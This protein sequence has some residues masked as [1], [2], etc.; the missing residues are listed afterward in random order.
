MTNSHKNGSRCLQVFV[1]TCEHGNGIHFGSIFESNRVYNA[2]FAQI[3]STKTSKSLLPWSNCQAV[4]TCLLDTII[5]QVLT[6]THIFQTQLH[7]FR[8]FGSQFQN[9]ENYSLSHWFLSSEKQ[10]LNTP[11]QHPVHRLPK[12]PVKQ[13]DEMSA[14]FCWDL[15]FIC[16]YH[17]QN[18]DIIKKKKCMLCIDTH[19]Q[20]ILFRSERVLSIVVETCT[21]TS[22]AGY[23]I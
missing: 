18:N 6:L 19:R 15:S 9:L 12:L 20:N 17:R 13:F 16:V 3:C 2:L 21:I 5:L 8:T 1:L 4:S 14:C 7:H 23:P 11:K 22:A 10:Y